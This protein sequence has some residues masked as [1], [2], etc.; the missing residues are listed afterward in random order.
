MKEVV[1][2]TT[3][4]EGREDDASISTAGPERI[5]GKPI[6]SPNRNTA[7]LRGI[8]TRREENGSRDGGYQ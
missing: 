5:I 8:E 2:V 6:T 4:G 3:Q 1:T 7:G